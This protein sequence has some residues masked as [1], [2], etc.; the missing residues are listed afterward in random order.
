MDLNIDDKRS[1]RDVIASDNPGNN[2][3]REILEYL[4]IKDKMGAKSL[5]INI[6]RQAVDDLESLHKRTKM[7]YEECASGNLI[8]YYKTTNSQRLLPFNREEDMT[9]LEFFYDSKWGNT[10]LE[11]LNLDVLP[12]SF[13]NKVD[14]LMQMRK[15]FNNHCIHCLRKTKANATLT[16]KNKIELGNASK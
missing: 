9:A 14:Y 8:G 10:L 5:T 3:I 15:V 1:I 7:F 13:R 4:R 16:K 12:S 11:F 6:I 2:D